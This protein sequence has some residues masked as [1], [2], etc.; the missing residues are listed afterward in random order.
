[1]YNTFGVKKYIFILLLSFVACKPCHKDDSIDISPSAIHFIDK[2]GSIS[3]E[4]NAT[5]DWGVNEDSE[6]LETEIREDG[7]CVVTA[8]PNDT[9]FRED[10]LIFYCGWDK[11]TLLVTQSSSNEFTVSP[12]N[13][14]FPYKGGSANIY[15]RCFN[16]WSITDKSDWISTDVMGG[17]APQSVPIT[18]SASD[19]ITET[20]GYVTFSSSEQNITVNVLRGAKPYIKL[21]KG[22]IETDGDGGN[23][24]IL[25]LANTPISISNEHDWIRCVN[26]DTISGILSLEIL[27][28]MEYE[29]REG[30]ITLASTQDTS[31]YSILNIRQGEKIDHPSL[32]FEEGSSMVISKRG[33]FTLHPIFTDMKDSALVWSSSDT[34]IASV[35]QKGTVQIHNSGECKINIT[36]FVHSVSAELSL[37]VK[38]IADSLTVMLGSQ[39]MNINK[40]AV[41]FPG[42]SMTIEVI[43]HP[44]GSYD[45]DLVCFS[46]APEIVEI[47]GYNVKCIAPGSATIR[48]ESQYHQL[49]REFTILVIDL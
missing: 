28:N 21:E 36:N 3:V 33:S 46:S 1:M 30:D 12:T 39:N 37:Q 25:Y 29:P 31:I 43:L 7:Y 9:L 4:V 34:D 14:T 26:N 23:V 10:S 18:I 16:D 44:E 8:T 20:Q 13:L 27:R 19:E 35:D 49:H 41:R 5:S 38:L 22:Y 42:E 15:V 40:T 47:D 32:G 6:W 17:S 48:V 2:G 45:K 11:T 24:K